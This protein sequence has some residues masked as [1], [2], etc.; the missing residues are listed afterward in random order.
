MV[1][2]NR[3][4]LNV[5]A[6]SNGFIRDSYEKMCRLSE[7]LAN[8]SNDKLLAHMLA[9]KGG[10][11]INIA[12]F[13]VPRLSLDIDMDLTIN[14]S[15]EE[16][17]E[18]R[19]QIFEHIDLMMRKLGY[20]YDEQHS[21]DTHALHSM[22]YKYCNAG[23]NKD[24]LKIEVNYMLR[25][26]I[27]PLCNFSIYKLDG[28]TQCDIKCVNPIEIYAAKI[29]AL[30]TRCAARDLFDLHYMISSHCFDNS[31]LEMLKKCS[32]LYAVLNNEK[33]FSKYDYSNLD[34]NLNI[35][36]VRQTLFPVMHQPVGKFDLE[37]M[38]KEIKEFS[39]SSLSFNAD[40]KKFVHKFYNGI[41][42]PSLLFDD[43]ELFGIVSEHPMLKWKLH[44]IKKSLSEHDD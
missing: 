19:K 22:V 21:K 38:I 44:N 23:G 32:I 24:R 18:I 28:F 12:F 11:A 43:S 41:M 40:E 34:T 16:T 3:D 15:K 10:T 5:F 20:T 8:I 2:Y 30:S 9:L 37:N 14:T 35:N 29:V 39:E 7:I 31:E 26:H 42:K 6:R 27:M 17:Q 25:S 1:K 33:S 4:E 36:K 13:E